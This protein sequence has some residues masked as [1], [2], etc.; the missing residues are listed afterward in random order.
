MGEAIVSAAAEAASDPT[1]TDVV[2]AVG[3]GIAALAAV[4]TVAVAIVAAL[5]AKRQ[6]QG[7]RDQLTVAGH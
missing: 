7:L 5:Y 6:V 3:A 4:A 2:S 1:W